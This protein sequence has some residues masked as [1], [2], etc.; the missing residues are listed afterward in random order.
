[1]SLPAA[2]T[3]AAKARRAKLGAKT[4]I[5]LVMVLVALPA[6]LVHWTTFLVLV[7]VAGL[8]A[9][10]EFRNLMQC[11][12]RP[13]INPLM[14]QVFGGLLVAVVL[15]YIQPTPAIAA[16]LAIVACD[17]MAQYSGIVLGGRLFRRSDGTRPLVSATSPNKTWEG[18]VGGMSAGIVVYVSVMQIGH[19]PVSCWTYLAGGLITG[20]GVCGD[21]A[22][23]SLKR[24]LNIK[25]TDTTF[26]A[27]GGAIDRLDSISG[28]YLAAGILGLIVWYLP[29]AWAAMQSVG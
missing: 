24:R 26:G 19:E 22:E 21:L 6:L 2:E 20:A 28:G 15:R 4:K 5:G 9:L 7:V 12:G 16:G 27:H 17:I 13:G 25:D 18:V 14:A 1:M 10:R 23:S 8:L 11:Y 29:A 3:V